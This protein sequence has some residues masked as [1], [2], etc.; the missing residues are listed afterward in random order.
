MVGRVGRERADRCGHGHGAGACANRLGARGARPVARRGSVFERALA[1]FPAV[2]VDARV[3][4][5]G[6]LR[7]GGG[8]FCFDRAFLTFLV[9]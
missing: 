4:R 5:G 2:G 1:H 7:D 3:Q 6:G 8:G 9:L